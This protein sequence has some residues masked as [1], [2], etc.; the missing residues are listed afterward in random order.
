LR[1]ARTGIKV[2]ENHTRERTQARKYVVLICI[3]GCRP[4]YFSFAD[5]PKIRK[6]MAEGVTYDQ[7][8]VGHLRNDTPPGH[9]TLVTGAFPA[10]HG[11]IGFHW[12]DPATGQLFKPTS[13]F[14]VARGQLNEFIAKSGCESIGSVFK[15]V[16]PGAKVAALSSNKFYAAAALGADSADFIGYCRY[17]PRRDFGTSVGQMLVPETVKGR[18]VPAE[19]M[20]DPALKRKVTNPW[21]GDS[22]TIDFAL[23]LFEREKPEVLL[24]NLALCDDIGH[25]YGANLGREQTAQIISNVDRQIGRLIDAYKRAG[26][27]ENTFFVITSDHGMSA[28][29]HTIDETPMAPIVSEYGLK[30]SAARLEFY[31]NNP[32]KAKEAAEKIASLK[33]DGIHAVYYKVKDDKGGYQYLPA[34]GSKVDSA[35]DA[36]YRYLTSTYASPQSPD[37]VCFPAENWNIKK[38]TEYFKGDHGTATWE[39]Q[40]I[41]LIIVGPG[42]KKGVISHA[43]ARLVDVAPTILAA[44]GLKSEKMDGVVLADA[45]VSAPEELVRAQEAVNAQLTPLRD[46]L[47]R[48]HDQD[49]MRTASTRSLEGARDAGQVSQMGQSERWMQYFK[50]LDRNKDGK[51]TREEAGNARWFDWLDRNKDGAITPDE[52]GQQTPLKPPTSSTVGK[53]KV[54]RKVVFEFTRDYTPGTRDS[55]GQMRTGQE[56]MRIIAYRGQ[57]F[58]GTSTF[59]DPR[60][61]TND[62]DYTGCQVLRKSSSKSEWE[63]DVS[64]GRRYLRIDCLEVVRFTRDANGRPLP[65]P[66]EMLVAGLWDIG[67]IGWLPPGSEDVIARMEVY[68]GVAKQIFGRD[69]RSAGLMVAGLNRYI[70]VAI[71]DDATGKWIISRVAR[72]PDSERGFASVRAMKV[73]RDKVTGREYLFI[74][75]SYGVLYKGV[76]DPSVP[77]KIRWLDDPE[78]D[79]SFGRIHSMCECNGSLYV[80]TDYGGLTVQNQRGGIFRRIDGVK[81]KWERVYFNYDP[82]YPTWN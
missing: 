38:A 67:E 53:V 41:P 72:V 19:I 42:I 63:V 6:L 77:G 51:V 68:R 59:T 36:C 69:F 28:N 55:K 65:K 66:V 70:T 57:L 73:Y 30:R 18:E 58:A 48:R 79:A 10:K 40:H 5:I 16:F 11:L 20:N 21:D 34:S 13:W 54:G 39:N 61:Y 31:V 8:W 37:L 60:I 82:R 26:V 81:P 74:G 27:Y 64:F 33:L 45:L 78:L 35:L 24:I 17:E 25:M 1:R 14:S 9:A 23:R 71:R 7:A 62:P 75:T 29:L 44:I 22:W 32:A 15:K 80:S 50:Q 46:A 12:Q 4:D 76:Y 43:P 3:D 52:I 2:P 49:L 56:L 47:K